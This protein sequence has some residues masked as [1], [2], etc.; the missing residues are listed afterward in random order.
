[1]SGEAATKRRSSHF[2]SHTMGLSFD[3]LFLPLAFDQICLRSFLQLK[4]TLLKCNIARRNLRW[5]V[6]TCQGWWR[7]LMG[8][9]ECHNFLGRSHYFLA[10]VTSWTKFVNSKWRC[11][12]VASTTP[13]SLPGPTMRGANLEAL[14][15]G[16]SG[17]RDAELVDI[18]EKLKPLS[19]KLADILVGDALP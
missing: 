6:I 4:G 1:M 18:V 16:Y 2:S 17:W 14:S 12:V 3:Y 11:S 7:L 9:L 13:L 5:S 8:S 10:S 19:H 15:T